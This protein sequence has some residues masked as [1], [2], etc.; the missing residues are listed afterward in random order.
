MALTIGSAHVLNAYDTIIA[1]ALRNA[2]T[3]ETIEL[4][5]AERAIFLQKFVL[6]P[7]SDLATSSLG[8]PSTHEP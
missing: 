2:A 7:V 3:P 5:Q 1:L 4:L 8:W 6:D